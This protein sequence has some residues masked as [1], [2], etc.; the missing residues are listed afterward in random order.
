MAKWPD[1]FM[2]MMK[3]LKITKSVHRSD[4]FRKKS[5]LVWPPFSLDGARKAYTSA[6]AFHSNNPRTSLDVI[7]HVYRCVKMSSS[8]SSLEQTLYL[9]DCQL[10][11]GGGKMMGGGGIHS[12][13]KMVQ[14]KE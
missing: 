1:W 5:D 6:L 13:T 7:F 11:H 12:V 3:S 2:S 8:T 9:M 14:P 4:N 10:W